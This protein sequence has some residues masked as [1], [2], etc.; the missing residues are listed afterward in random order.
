MV[1]ENGIKKDISYYPEK[2]LDGNVKS[3]IRFHA[4]VS[5]FK[6]ESFFSA[7]SSA[8]VE[9]FRAIKETVHLFWQLISGKF[10]FSDSLAGPVRISY[11]IGQVSTSGFHSFI[12]LLAMISISLGVANLLPLPGLDGGSIVLSMIEIIRRKTF[13]PR[14]YIRFQTIGVFLLGILMLFVLFSDAQFLLS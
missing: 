6:G 7:F 2:D 10:S 13:S 5:L 4:E 8:V 12:Q 9:T 3:N 1:D 11:I 14:L